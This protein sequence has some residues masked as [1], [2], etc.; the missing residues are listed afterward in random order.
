[1]LFDGLAEDLRSQTIAGS[2][3]A[4]MLVTAEPRHVPAGDWLFRQGD[5][6]DSLYVV[7][8]GSLEV[9]A[10]EP[11]PEVLR[12]L[13]RGDVVGEVALLT[14]SERSTGVRA[15]RDTYLMRVTRDAFQQLLREDQDFTLAVT[16]HLGEQLQAARPATAPSHAPPHVITLVPLGPRVDVAGFAERL[17]GA[18]RRFG[19]VDLLREEDAGSEDSFGRLLNQRERKHERVLIVAGGNHAWTDFAIRTADRAVALCDDSSVPDT[20]PDPRL[21]GCELAFLTKASRPPALTAWVA[22]LDTHAVHLIRSH[23]AG[24]RMARRLAGRS[25]GVVLSGGG[26][27]GLAHI[28]VVAEL[29]SAGVAIDRFGGTSMGAY[30][31]AAFASGRSAEEVLRHCREEFV[32]RNPLSDYTLPVYAVLR[33]RKSREML[34]RSFGSIHIEELP[35]DFFCVSCDLIE[36]RTVVHRRGSVAGALGASMCLPAIFPPIPSEGRLLVDGGVLDNL[37]V[38]EMATRGEGPVI[39]VDVSAQFEPPRA[40]PRA[41]T[42]RTRMAGHAR[43]TLTGWSTTRVPNIKETLIRSMVLG[44]LDPAGALERGA[45]LVISPVTGR[46]PLTAFGGIDELVAVGR[47]AGRRSATAALALS[48]KQSS[49]PD[50]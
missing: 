49:G 14:K 28:G 30:I 26:A 9:V 4:R 3:W 10:E 45:D 44:S 46:I 15:R 37:P 20:A 42:R 31:A 36:A 47:D 7:I 1:M 17:A 34:A 23:D 41:E 24:D 22:A 21:R 6:A 13:A 32:R 2:P 12:V 5:P 27:R 29:V 50:A 39:A 38:G 8:S 48:S 19:S 18:L 40:A 25:V 16:R 11:T 43:E 33:T 35:L